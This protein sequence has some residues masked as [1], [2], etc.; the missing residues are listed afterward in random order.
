[1]K[2]KAIFLLVI[3]LLNTVVGFA[4]ALGMEPNQED[5]H[6]VHSLSTA[7]VHQEHEHSSHH[8]HKDNAQ[9]KN[10]HDQEVNQ[11][12]GLSLSEG[13]SCC[14]TLV[15]D[16]LIQH[17]VLPE[18]SKTI[19]VMPVLWLSKAYCHLLIP[20]SNLEQDRKVYVDHR[21]RPPDKDIRISIQSF[22]I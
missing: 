5:D 17:K 10:N 7:V 16:L 14:T 22:Q 8:D 11:I 1:M 9:Q 2:S 4:C 21:S 20:V 3:F 6:Q 12:L 15:K 19:V 13:E 18:S